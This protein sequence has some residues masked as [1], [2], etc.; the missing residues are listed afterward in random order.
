M[1]RIFLTLPV[2]DRNAVFN[3][4]S[5]A[6]IAGLPESRNPYREETPYYYEWQE[7]WRHCDKEW[8]RDRED[9]PS[10]PEIKEAS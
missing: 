7:G 2:A 10:L 9:A 8:G 1:K 6:R 3:R 4:G 5:D